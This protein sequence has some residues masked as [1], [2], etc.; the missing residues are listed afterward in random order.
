MSVRDEDRCRSHRRRRHR[1]ETRRTEQ[2]TPDNNVDHLIKELTDPRPK[3][4]GIR[5]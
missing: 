4:T 1:C 3:T 5:N 2:E